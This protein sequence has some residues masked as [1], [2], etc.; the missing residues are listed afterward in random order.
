MNHEQLEES[1]KFWKSIDKVICIYIHCRLVCLCI[2]H[3][4]TMYSLTFVIQLANKDFFELKWPCLLKASR[5]TS[6]IWHWVRPSRSGWT[7]GSAG[8]RPAGI[9]AIAAVGALWQCQG[10]CILPLS[11]LHPHPHK[12]GAAVGRPYG[13]GR[14]GD[15][16]VSWSDVWKSRF[17]CGAGLKCY[18]WVW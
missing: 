13:T 2:H 7:V 14:A 10:I 17:G 6:S 9:Q 15:S 11:S 4:W 16:G 3:A 18:G 8:S 1:W 5:S 12:N